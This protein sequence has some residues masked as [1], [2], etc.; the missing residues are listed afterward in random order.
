MRLR[1]LRKR[2]YESEA[3][4]MRCCSIAMLRFYGIEKFLRCVVEKAQQQK[5]LL[6]TSRN[7]LFRA[8]PRMV[9]APLPAFNCL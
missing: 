5:K 2:R 7:G 3:P 4:A 1:R 6:R 9:Q 8:R